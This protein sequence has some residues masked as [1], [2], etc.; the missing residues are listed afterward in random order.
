[1]PAVKVKKLGE[2]VRDGTEDVKM[3]YA[4]MKTSGEFMTGKRVNKILMDILEKLENSYNREVQKKVLAQFKRL[5]T[6]QSRKI[7]KRKNQI[8]LDFF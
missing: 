6:K 4:S 7:H 3:F 2:K 8:P 1:M 5:L